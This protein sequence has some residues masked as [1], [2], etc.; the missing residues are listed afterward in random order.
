MQKVIRDFI[1]DR[2]FGRLY[3]SGLSPLFYS[4][5]WLINFASTMDLQL[6]VCKI[7]MD[8]DYFHPPRTTMSAK[9]LGTLVMIY[10]TDELQNPLPLKTILREGDMNNPILRS[11]VFLHN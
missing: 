4:W 6:F 8:I 3:Y 7:L 5:E 2:T 1:A 9:S 10:A 11:D